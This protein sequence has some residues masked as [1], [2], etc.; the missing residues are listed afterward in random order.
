MI[1]TISAR[2]VRFHQTRAVP[3][4]DTDAEARAMHQGY[5]LMPRA[6][7]S[8]AILE[9]CL[10][11]LAVAAVLRLMWSDLGSPR[12]VFEILGAARSLPA[13]VVAPDRSAP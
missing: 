3:F 6:D 13:W 5:A 8:R 4:F 9:P 7:F 2:A 1:E 10:P 12:R 11:S